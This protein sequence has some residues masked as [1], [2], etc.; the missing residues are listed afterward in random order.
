MKQ[1]M[2]KHKHKQIAQVSLWRVPLPISQTGGNAGSEN[3][4][5]NTI[6]SKAQK[7]PQDSWLGGGVKF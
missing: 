6:R 3:N 1:K 4:E 2:P 7:K 5:T